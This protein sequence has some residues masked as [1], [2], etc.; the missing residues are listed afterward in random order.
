MNLIEFLFSYLKDNYKDNPIVKTITEN[1]LDLKRA[2]NGI[3]ME[4]IGALLGQILNSR[5]NQKERE[6]MTEPIINIADKDIVYS[7]NRYFYSLP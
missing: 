6:F 3:S 4:D 2:L 7:L 5:S 1:G